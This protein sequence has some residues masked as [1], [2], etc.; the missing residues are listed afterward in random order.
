MAAGRNLAIKGTAG[1][2][3]LCKDQCVL[4]LLKF[5]TNVLCND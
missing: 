5:K 1:I 2:K 4:N 3:G